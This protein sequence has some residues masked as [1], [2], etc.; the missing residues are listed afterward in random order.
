MTIVDAGLSRAAHDLS[1]VARVWADPLGDCIATLP[2]AVV[3]YGGTIAVIAP[4]PYL[5]R[6]FEATGN[7]TP[8]LIGSAVA[9]AAVR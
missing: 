6:I 9:T 5:V 2:S 7:E 1:V 8:R 4:G 3:D